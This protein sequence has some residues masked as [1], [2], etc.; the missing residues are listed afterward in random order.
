MIIAWV[1]VTIR[2]IFSLPLP[3]Y[4]FKTCLQV[5]APALRANLT[6]ADNQ[7]VHFTELQEADLDASVEASVESLKLQLKNL[8]RQTK[9]AMKAKVEATDKLKEKDEKGEPKFSI[10]MMACGTVDDFH[11]GLQDR[12]G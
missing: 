3:H 2:V 1:C 8:H 7:L 9:A 6:A 10:R 4:Q 11:L 12:I 5:I